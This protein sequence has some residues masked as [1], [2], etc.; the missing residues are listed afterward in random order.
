MSVGLTSV[1][2]AQQAP[3]FTP[4]PTDAFTL[5]APLGANLCQGSPSLVYPA[6]SEPTHH[7]EVL[8]RE[9]VSDYQHTLSR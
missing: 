2:N 6:N 9:F 8:A 3:Q 4:D 1:A 5:Q 7:Q